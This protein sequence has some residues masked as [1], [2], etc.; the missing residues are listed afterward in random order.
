MTNPAELTTRERIVGCIGMSLA[1][2]FLILVAYSLI[3]ILDL[4]KYDKLIARQIIVAGFAV[5]VA[6]GVVFPRPAL[7]IARIFFSAF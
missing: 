5:G 1:I 2:P 7:R 6:L 4:L 3:V